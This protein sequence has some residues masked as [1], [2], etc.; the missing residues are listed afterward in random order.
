M[1]NALGTIQNASIIR[2]LANIRLRELSGQNPNDLG[3][4]ALLL[5]PLALAFAK[6]SQKRIEKIFWWLIFFIITSLITFTFSRAGMVGM[7]STFLLIAI[8]FRNRGIEYGN[9]NLSFVLVFGLLYYVWTE[10]VTSGVM[11]SGRQL[12]YS[13]LSPE[14]F[15]RWDLVKPALC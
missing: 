1:I 7:F 3:W 9:F 14:L 10:A 11:D 4:T 2:A 15:K 5:L 12:T 8:F 6:I 13:G